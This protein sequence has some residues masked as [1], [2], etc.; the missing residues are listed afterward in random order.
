[1]ESLRDG[2]EVFLSGDRVEDVTEHPAFRNSVRSAAHLY[3]YQSAPEKVDKM[4]FVSP[5]S[6]E[7]VSRC[8]QLPSSHTEL[9]ARREALTAWAETH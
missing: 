4:T 7:A 6:G 3:D 9:V 8:W 5:D 2:R 1:L